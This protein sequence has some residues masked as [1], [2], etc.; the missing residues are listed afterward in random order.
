MSSVERGGRGLQF[1]AGA[2]APRLGDA[3]AV[4]S[5]TEF[6]K[7]YV[8]DAEETTDL[9]LELQDGLETL[10]R[11]RRRVPRDDAALELVLR[12]GPADRL[13]PYRDFHEPP[14]RAAAPRP[15]GWGSTNTP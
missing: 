14:R 1:L 11:R 7:H 10:S 3:T 4:N 15:W 2:N 12:S 9:P 5:W 8:G 13:E 6:V